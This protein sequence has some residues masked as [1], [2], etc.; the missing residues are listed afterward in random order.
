MKKAEK[1]YSF[2]SN[3]GEVMKLCMNITTWLKLKLIL[4]LNQS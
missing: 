4:I 3:P 2:P 1:S